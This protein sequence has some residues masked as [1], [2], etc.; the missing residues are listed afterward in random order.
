MSMEPTTGQGSPECKQTHVDGEQTETSL[1]S[2]PNK[3]TAMPFIV[4]HDKKKK[5]FYINI[6]D[7]K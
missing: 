6:T 3:D 7:G 4:G 2:N 1:E 5:E